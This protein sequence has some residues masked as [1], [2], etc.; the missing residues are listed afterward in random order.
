MS[1]KVN[2]GLRRNYSPGQRVLVRRATDLVPLSGVIFAN[3]ATK[4]GEWTVE[5]DALGGRIKCADAE[6]APD[7]RRD[8]EVTYLRRDGTFVAVI[9][10]MIDVSIW[11]PSYAIREKDAFSGETYDTNP[12][13]IWPPKVLAL[14]RS[15]SAAEDLLEMEEEETAAAAGGKKGK[16][17]GKK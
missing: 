3:P 7:V 16:K 2:S 8:E 10:V 13:R 14:L 12:G 1:S 9:V 15:E 17:G 4:G 11:P 5:G 6:V